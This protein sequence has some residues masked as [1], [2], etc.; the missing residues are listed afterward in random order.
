MAAWCVLF[1]GEGRAG[2]WEEDGS[3]RGQREKGEQWKV[4]ID[5]GELALSL[6]KRRSLA[7]S[8]STSSPL[9]SLSFVSHSTVSLFSTSKNAT[10]NTPLPLCIL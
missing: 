4:V 10:I 9:F 6:F 3:G 5:V 7:I 1:P 8:T 2:E